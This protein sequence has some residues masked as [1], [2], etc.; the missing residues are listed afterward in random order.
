MMAAT[1]LA[2]SDD[3]DERFI[4]LLLLEQDRR[5]WMTEMLIKFAAAVVAVPVPDEDDDE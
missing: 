1:L 2:A 4:G 5:Q 3:K